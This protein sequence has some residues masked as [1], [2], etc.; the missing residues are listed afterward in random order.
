MLTVYFLENAVFGGYP[1]TRHAYFESLQ[2]SMKAYLFRIPLRDLHSQLAIISS[3]LVAPN[4][5]VVK[6]VGGDG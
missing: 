2:Y 6:V 3:N 5:D 4:S 1:G